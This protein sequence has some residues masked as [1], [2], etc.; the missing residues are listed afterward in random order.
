MKTQ[1]KHMFHG[2]ALTQIVE[3]PSF[4]ALN[5]AD[6]YYGHYLINTRRHLLVKYSTKSGPRWQFTFDGDDL[7]VIDSG[8]G[9]DGRFLVGLVCGRKTACC[10]NEEEIQQVLDR[11][12][13]S[14]QWV[15]VECPPRKSMEVHGSG[16]RLSKK[17]THKSFPEKIFQG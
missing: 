4:K 14:Q 12:S 9:R 5:K 7:C 17:V 6:S 3:H 2:V 10:L 15:A 16:G 8:L 11:H 1:E 13:S